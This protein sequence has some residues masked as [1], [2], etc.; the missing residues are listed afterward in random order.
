MRV[1]PIRVDRRLGLV[2]PLRRKN[3]RLELPK[4][5]PNWGRRAFFLLLGLVGVLAL[6]V[7]LDA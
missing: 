2:T 4:A 3:V 7:A 1:R 6:A 5:R